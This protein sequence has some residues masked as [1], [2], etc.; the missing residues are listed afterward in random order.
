VTPTFGPV[1]AAAIPT[2]S[3]GL[4]ALLGAALAGAAIFLIRKG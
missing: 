1:L 4:L 3:P 2:L